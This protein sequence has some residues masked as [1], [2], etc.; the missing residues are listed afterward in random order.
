MHALYRLQTRL[1]LTAPEASALFAIAAALALGLGVQQVRQHAA[2]PVA[3]LYAASDAAFAAAVQDAPAAEPQTAAES[4]Q[5]PERSTAAREPTAASAPADSTAHG[6]AEPEAEPAAAPPVRAVGSVADAPRRRSAK[7]PPVRVN[8]NTGRAAELQR[9]PGIGPKLAERVIAFRNQHGPFRHP[10]D[11]VEV[12]G[13]GPK[14]Y[15]KMR[16]WAHL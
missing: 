6:H 5:A 3:D 1:G 12:K 13:I 2:P 14:T 9:L 7:P 11:I 10:A 16:P 15:E 4:S 8:L